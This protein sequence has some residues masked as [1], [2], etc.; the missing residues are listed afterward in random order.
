MTE[1]SLLPGPVS[2]SAPVR[3]ALQQ[4]LLHHRSEEFLSLFDAVRRQLCALAG[5]REV[6]LFPGSGTVANDVIAATLAAT[7]THRGLILNNGEFGKRLVGQAARFGLRPQVLTWNWGQPWDPEMIA[8]A[9]DDLPS[10]GWVWG[11]HH[12]TSTGMLNDLPG[13]MELA[14]QRDVRVCIDAIS[15]LGAEPLDLRDIFLASSTSGKALGSCSGIAMV[16]AN[17]AEIVQLDYGRVPTS[18]DLAAGMAHAGPRFTFPSPPLH[19]MAAALK[20]YAAP[21]QTR[22]R[23]ECYT[24]LGQYVRGELRRLGLPPLA[25]DRHASSTIATF[26]APNGWDSNSFVELCRHAGFLIGGQSTYLSER[27]LVQIATMG[28][29]RQQDCEAFFQFLNS[30]LQFHPPGEPVLTHINSGRS[31]VA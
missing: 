9:L 15:S 5:A 20:E 10:G 31:S 7:G 17:P 21:A 16:F 22:L 14:R 27:R 2:L 23:F 1:I 11:V 25:D 8:T 6:A 4:P 3:A 12:E 26:S 13:L 24:A 29:I 18:L 30:L 19:A 28:A